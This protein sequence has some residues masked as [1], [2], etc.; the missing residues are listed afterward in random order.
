M[1]KSQQI[2]LT[3][4]RVEFMEKWN[5]IWNRNGPVQEAAALVTDEKYEGV[6]DGD[7][8]LESISEMEEENNEDGG[9]YYR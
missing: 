2:E 1:P 4:L 7:E 8:F 3:K 6:V 5:E 9:V